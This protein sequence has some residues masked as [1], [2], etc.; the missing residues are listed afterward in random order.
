MVAMSEQ[1]TADEAY[2]VL[3]RHTRGDLR[4][5]EVLDPIRFVFAPDGRLAAPASA[6]MLDALDTVLFAPAFAEG[7]MEVQVTLQPLDPDTAEGAVTDRW[8]IYHGD[9]QEARWAWLDLD[10][11]RYREWVVDG[12]A[13]RRPNP[14]AADEAGLCKAVNQDSRDDLAR[15][16]RH[17]A[18]ADVEEPLLVGIDG[19]GLDVRR[20]FDVVRVTAPRPMNT[21]EEARKVF[22][23]MVAEAR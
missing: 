7:A 10:A 14:L 11:A 3:R 4:H 17:F 20:R 2:A 19:H 22:Q 18:D 21:A 6:P 5:D 9:P 1:Q 12:E 13:L 16:C 23:Q 15:V 8:R